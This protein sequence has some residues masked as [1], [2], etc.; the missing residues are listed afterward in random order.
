L[1]DVSTLQ[2]DLYNVLETGEG[3]TDEIAQW[4]AADIAKSLKRQLSPRVTKG[5]GTL[6]LSNLGTPCSRKLWYH[7]HSKH[8]PEPLPASTLNKFIFGDLT[9]SHVLG[10]VK[11]SGHD[12]SG[13][14]DPVDVFGIRGHR[15]CVID[16]ML[17]DVKSASSRAFEKFKHHRLREDDPFGYISQLSSYLYGSLDDPLVTHKTKAGFLAVD[18]QFGHIAVD[19]YDLSEEIEGKYEEVLKVQHAVNEVE[20]PPRAFEPV[21]HN[22]SGNTKLGTQCSYCDFKKYCY[23]NA[24]KF[25]YSNGPVWMVDVVKEPTGSVFEDTEWDK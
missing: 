10:L 19:I 24:R 4:V 5:K 17:F 15:D 22:K 14:Q 13:L 11:A 25:L 16:G 6:R 3:Y 21:P 18:K 20:P 23:P 9:E 1:K 12:L 2:K 7:V 8:E